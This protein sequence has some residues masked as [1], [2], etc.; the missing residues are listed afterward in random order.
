LSSAWFVFRRNHVVYHAYDY[1]TFAFENRQFSV[2]LSEVE[3][4]VYP[5]YIELITSKHIYHRYWNTFSIVIS[6]LFGKIVILLQHFSRVK[7]SASRWQQEYKYMAIGNHFLI[8]IGHYNWQLV[9]KQ[10]QIKIKQMQ[11]RSKKVVNK[12]NNKQK[13]QALLPLP[14]V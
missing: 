6:K 8:K 12:N 1:G 3:F 7:Y 11:R 5:N 9:N 10:K 4:A 2:Q 14:W 13:N